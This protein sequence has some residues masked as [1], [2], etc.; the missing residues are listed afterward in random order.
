MVSIA[1]GLNEGH[2]SKSL[3]EEA[4]LIPISNIASIF[5]YDSKIDSVMDHQ[6]LL[7]AYGLTWFIQLCYLSY[8]ARKWYSSRKQKP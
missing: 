7:V 3:H 8:V 4:K 6:H 5:P 2:T 1:C